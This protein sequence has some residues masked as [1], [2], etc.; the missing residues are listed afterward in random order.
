VSSTAGLSASELAGVLEQLPIGVVVVDRDGRPLSVNAAAREFIGTWLESRPLLDLAL[1]GAL[2]DAHTGEFVTRETTPT[3]RALGGEAVAG[4]EFTSNVAGRTVQLRVSSVPLREADGTL[5]G[6]VTIL[7]DITSELGQVKRATRLYALEQRARSQTEQAMALLEQELAERR[8]AEEELLRSEQRLR[9][10]LEASHMGTWDYDVEADRVEWSDEM[11][12]IIGRPPEADGGPMAEAFGQV[13]PDDRAGV[14]QAVREALERGNDL[15]I[16]A[17]LV[18]GPGGAVRW[19]LAK[20]RVYRDENARPLRM[21]GIAMDITDRKEA[22]AARQSMAHS[23]RLRALGEMASGIAHDLNQSLALITGYSDMVRQELNLGAPNISRVRDMIDIT[24]RAALEGGKALR[25]LLSFVRTQSAIAEIER[26]DLSEVV[27]D[28][29]RLTAPRW[30]DA[31]QAEGR[32]IDLRV[33]TE[34]GCWINGSPT[35]LREAITNLIFNAVDALPFGGR[36]ELHCRQQGEHILVEVAD[37]GTGMPPEVRDR[38]FE[39]F[40]TTKGE[41]GTGLGLPQVLGTVERHGGT[42]DL[43]SAPGQGTTFRMKFPRASPPPMP[44][45]E[46]AEKAAPTP[47]QFIQILVVEDEER[48]STM[49]RHVLSQRG[50]K[51]T[52]A[53]DGEQACAALEQQRFDLVI[54]DLGLGAGKNG[55]DLAQVVEDR[56]PATHF[57]LV[58]GWGAAID[59]EEARARGVDAVLP[60][61]YRI[62]DLRQIADDVAARLDKR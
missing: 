41:K 52:V 44:V 51:V 39:L 62:A 40:F 55:W 9:L 5:A 12:G 53:A 22:E 35:E 17:R 61:P 29:A 32:P 45:R 38:V 18:P 11:A 3:R 42:L 23:Q 49:A 58:T 34:P 31:P 59:P 47:A 16:E 36:I 4:Q 13:H 54:S 26:I 8:R 2:R 43:D 10:A 57:V 14:E 15:Q 56:W 37:T 21:T 48:L 1:S 33:R 50:H 19:L 60:K 30:R 6:A 25:G 20:G 28:V 7:A 24:G 46:V 27:N